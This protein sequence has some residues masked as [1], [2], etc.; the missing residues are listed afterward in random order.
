MLPRR[1]RKYRRE[2]LVLFQLILSGKQ[3]RDALEIQYSS[4]GANLEAR[5]RSIGGFRKCIATGV[6][7]LYG[8]FSPI[9]RLVS[10]PFP[11]SRVTAH[12]SETRQAR[13]TYRETGWVAAIIREA[14][15]DSAPERLK[16]REEGGLL[17][18]L[19]G[20]RNVVSKP[21][22]SST[23]PLLRTLSD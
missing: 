4:R 13:K 1:I 12:L 15:V 8:V 9:C 10:K 2:E 3:I 7:N 16:G 5:S 11:S 17:L 18:F 21:K 19:R 6:P 22:P 14:D 20:R 23:I